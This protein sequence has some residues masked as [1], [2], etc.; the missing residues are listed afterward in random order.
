VNLADGTPVARVTVT[1]VG[2]IVSNTTLLA[3]EHSAEGLYGITPAAHRQARVGHRWR[4]DEQGSDY[5]AVLDFGQAVRPEAISVESLLPGEHVHLRGLTLIDERTG[6]NRTVTVDPAYRLVHSG[7]VKI[8][9]NLAVLPRAFIVHQASV[10][11]DDEEV[12][13]LLQDPAFDPISQVILSEGDALQVEARPSAVEIIG[14][15][16]EEVQLRASLGAP[17]YMVLTDA[18]YPG[19]KAT[20]DGQPV[21][22]LR[23]DLYFRAIALEDGE[24]LVSLHFWPNSARIGLA[25]SLGAWLI[26]GLILAVLAL[27]T[28]RKA[29]S[30]V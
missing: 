6:T 5:V 10:V 8:Y 7:D 22:I 14:Y 9:Q 3:G 1:D 17:G 23:A 30:G 27:R 20:V 2:G 4:D 24:H 12:L 15:E 28:G 21:P 13:A 19:W 18:D 16:P 25:M 11:D 26:S 29:S